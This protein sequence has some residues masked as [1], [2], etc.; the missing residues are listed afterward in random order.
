MAKENEKVDDEFVEEDLSKLDDTTD[1]KAK[2]E[3]LEQ[4]RREDGIRQRERTK[5]LKERLTELEAKKSSEKL[6]EKPDDK[7]LE[8]LDK[9]ALQ[10]AGI[11]EAD[12]EELFDKW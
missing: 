11:T 2:A 9:M 7:L 8:R 6:S 5:A 10:V 12:E 3:E 1:W 4:K